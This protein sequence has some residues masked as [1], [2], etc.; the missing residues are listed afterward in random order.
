VRRTAAKGLLAVRTALDARAVVRE[1]R[2]LRE[3]EPG[4]LR[5]TCKWAPVDAWTAADL[6]ALREAVEG[7]RERIGPRQRWRMTVDKHRHE[8]YHRDEVIRAL[9]PL[10]DAPVDLT[11]PERILKIDL[12]GAEA[13]LA[14]VGPEDI[15]S[16]TRPPGPPPE[17]SPT[18]HSRDAPA[19]SR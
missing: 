14:V 6:E 5:F 10:V 11:H 7:L 9:A 3:R 18:D 12:I 17:R 1:L 2:A 19:A 4:R 15:F 16:T 13:A 8:R